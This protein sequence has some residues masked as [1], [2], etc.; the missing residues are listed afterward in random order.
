MKRELQLKAEAELVA[1]VNRQEL[2]M[3]E[4]RDVA[5][6][7]S[8]LL[9]EIQIEEQ[10]A[11]ITQESSVVSSTQAIAVELQPALP[12][13][14]ETDKQLPLWT[15]LVVKLQHGLQNAGRFYQ[16]T[17]LEIGEG[18]GLAQGEPFWNVYLNRWQVIVNFACGCKSVACDWVTAIA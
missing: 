9:Q 16:E 15:G 12:T 7:V 2:P 14:E 4:V 8:P 3:I 5:V 17:F 18:V 6:E 13:L 10:P 1:K 11:P